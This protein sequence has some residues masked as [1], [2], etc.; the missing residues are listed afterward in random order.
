[1]KKIVLL[2]VT[3]VLAMPLLLSAQISLSDEKPEQGESIT[4]QLEAPASMLVIAYRPNSSVVR[5]DTLFS[6]TPA[7][8]FSWTPERAGVVA[9]STESASRNVSVRFQGFSWEG[10]LVMVLAGAI[11]FGGAIFAFRVL[12][13]EAEE[14]QSVDIDPATRP[15][16]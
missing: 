7:T 6:D 14:G 13:S 5:R 15:D 12:F 11:L 3:S 8:E 9:L 1:M 10:L 16:T 2:L 4:V